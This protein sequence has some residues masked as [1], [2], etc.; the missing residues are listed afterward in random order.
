[1]WSVFFAD[2]IK[3]IVLQLMIKS[4][5]PGS[6]N[7]M[8]SLRALLTTAMMIWKRWLS[9]PWSYP[10]RI[11]LSQSQNQVKLIEREDLVAIG[12][13]GIAQQNY[14]LE[15]CL[16]LKLWFF[17][18][19]FNISLWAMFSKNEWFTLWRIKRH[20]IVQGKLRDD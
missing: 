1:M 10:L 13:H 7:W 12:V 9:S 11:F 19:K 14:L 3:I 8:T 20:L 6:W 17:I 15:R 4:P 16:G 2:I 18:F 5:K